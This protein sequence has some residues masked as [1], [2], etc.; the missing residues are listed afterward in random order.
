MDK[1][2][3]LNNSPTKVQNPKRRRIHSEHNE[4]IPTKVQNSKRRRIQL[5]HNDKSRTKVQNSKRRWIQSEHDDQR[6]DSRET[7]SARERKHHRTD[8]G[9]SNDKE[10]KHQGVKTKKPLKRKTVRKSEEDAHLDVGFQTKKVQRVLRSSIKHTKERKEKVNKHPNSKLRLQ[11]KKNGDKK[12]ELQGRILPEKFKNQGT[13]KKTTKPRVRCSAFNR[14]PI[15]KKEKQLRANKRLNSKAESFKK[16]K[17]KMINQILPKNK[18]ILVQ[19]KQN[20]V[21]DETSAKTFSSLFLKKIKVKLHH[22]LDHTWA[23]IHGISVSEDDLVWVNHLVNT[24]H[25]QNTTGEVIRTFELDFRP[26]FNCCTPSGDVFL[27]QGYGANA[28]PTISLLSREGDIKVVADLSSYASNLCGILCQDERIYVVAYCAEDKNYFVIKL[29]INGEVENVYHTQKASDNINQ[30]ISL[31]GQIAAIRTN[32][33]GLMPLEADRISS[34][35][36][37]KVNMTLYSA[38]ASVDKLGN[39]IMASNASLFIINPSLEYMHEIDTG[40]S[41]EIISTAVDQQNQLWFGTRSGKLYST[42]YLK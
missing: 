23:N 15:P 37:N 10:A 12:E 40:T 18:D 7:Q 1:V 36:M 26:V 3:H 11:L 21:P 29:N 20:T 28:K 4:N 16:S 42:K 2:C 41:E 13:Q 8:V 30:I 38:S 39:V 25:L 33:D 31:N 35:K 6:T 22:T 27:T 34:V 24:V 9:E 5:D 32:S 17:A 19:E 14:K